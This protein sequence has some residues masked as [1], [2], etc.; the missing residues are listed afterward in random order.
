MSIK[1]GDRIPSVTLSYMSPEGIKKIT[2]DELFTGKRV[3]LFAVPGAFT[4]ACSERHLPGFVALSGEIKARGVDNIACVSVN[5]AYVMGAWSKDRNVDDK[6]MML[7]DGS[8]EF[9]K[10]IGQEL[11]LKAKGLGIRSRRYAM[12]VENGVVKYQA[13]EEGGKL[14]ISTAENILERL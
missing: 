9:T 11:D 8:G 5:D 14:E 3:V 7:A 13:L 1:V 10:A 12:I 6:V 4:P 2:T